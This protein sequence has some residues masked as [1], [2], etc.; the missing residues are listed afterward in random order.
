[1]TDASGPNNGGATHDWTASPVW[2]TKF[3]VCEYEGGCT[4][5]RNTDGL[6]GS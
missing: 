3:R 5:Y 4:A 2:I 6:G 1:M